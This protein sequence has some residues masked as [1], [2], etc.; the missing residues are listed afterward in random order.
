MLAWIFA[1][2]MLGI[3]FGWRSLRDW[4]EFHSTKKKDENDYS[5]WDD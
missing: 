1:L 4:F 3:I 5:F 2:S